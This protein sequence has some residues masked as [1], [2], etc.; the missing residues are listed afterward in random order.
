MAKRIVEYVLGLLYPP[1]CMF[2]R[3]L[4]EDEQ[5]D[6]CHA[7]R[8]SLPYFDAPDRTGEFFTRCVSVYE[9]QGM[10]R[11]SL[12]RYKFAGMQQYAGG[13]GRAIAMAL[14]RRDLPRLDGVTWVPV[15]KK[16]KRQRGYDQAQLLAQAVARELQ[17]PLLPT[18]RKTVDNPP[19]SSLNGVSRRRGNVIGVYQCIDPDAVGG[20]RLLLIDDIITTGSTLS[21]CSRVLR[22]AGASEIICG[23][24]AATEVNE[25]KQ[26]TT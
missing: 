10:V 17:L 6:I 7:C 21:E 3:R 12:H 26:V 18:L 22:S 4:L 13:Y 2:C 15:S 20:K 11:E 9:Y 5:T 1:K 25:K 14:S 8:K 19:Q 24:V 16:R 23:T